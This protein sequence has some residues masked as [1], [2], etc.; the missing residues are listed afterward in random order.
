MNI[1]P[2]IIC[3]LGPPC[4]GKS[5]IINKIQKDYE[6]HVIYIGD[7][8]RNS[9]ATRDSLADRS[10]WLLAPL[11]KGFKMGFNTPRKVHYKCNVKQARTKLDP[12]LKKL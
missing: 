2:A 5:T 10:D 8:L 11:Y 7:V 9:E 12:R 1:R 4:S 6:F 3:L